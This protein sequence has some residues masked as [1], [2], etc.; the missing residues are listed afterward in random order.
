MSKFTIL[1]I[2]DLHKD[3]RS[4]Y[5]QLL[6]S[7]ESDKAKWDK[8]GVVSP[9]FIVVSGDL[10]QG[11]NIG[12]TEEDATQQLRHQYS[13]T[14]TFLEKLTN[15]FLKGQK[16]RMIMVPGNHDVNRNVCECSM[17]K[18][19]ERENKD[20]R[21]SIE[22]GH[23]QS[24]IYRWSWSDF[25]YYKIIDE[26][27]Y[28]ERFNLYKDFY[29]HF[30]NKERT[31]DDCINEAQIFDFPEENITFSCFNSC[32]QIDH[33]S[34]IGSI[35]NRA[36]NS[37]RQDLEQAYDKGR[38]IIGV[39]HH[40]VY[41][42][43]YSTNFMDR[44][45]LRHLREYHIR[46]GLF[47]HQHCS[48]VADEYVDFEQKALDDDNSLLLISS[49]TLFGNKRQMPP[50]V[51]RQY[52]LIEIEISY[53]EALVRIY[54]R[55]DSTGDSTFPIWNKHLVE[56][57]N[58]IEH[59][60]MLKKQSYQN[61]IYEI[62]RSVRTEGNYKRGIEKFLS[63]LN[64][65][66]NEEELKILN[67]Y[68]DDYVKSLDINEDASFLSDMMKNPMT[69]VQRAYTIQALINTSRYSEAQEIAVTINNPT[70]IEKLSINNLKKATRWKR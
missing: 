58:F 69:R 44:N 26:D 18:I 31:V 47:G 36:L 22:T 67:S 27:K 55:E 60:V 48:E 46:I 29:N 42:S 70:E 59:R 43:P 56:P 52:N 32:N 40:H 21:R 35:S 19:D 5:D 66:L 54:T 16:S 15:T 45:V 14:G 28:N 33:L 65:D 51:R 68:I 62:D 25:C 9:S 30:Y 64:Q 12:L 11:V 3:P 53:G 63:L 1:H 4:D 6:C 34:D 57:N 38:L 23:G 8:M 39:W 41:G 7:L 20:I 50:G 61:R 10:V 24:N 17:Q 49:G 37:C 13:E 2:S